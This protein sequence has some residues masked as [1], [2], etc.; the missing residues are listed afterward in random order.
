M[1]HPH[2]INECVEADR[3]YKNRNICSTT[4]KII[5]IYIIPHVD[6]N[7]IM[8]MNMLNDVV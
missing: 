6:I 4:F 7:F 5:P 1:I 2:V 3:K 8:P